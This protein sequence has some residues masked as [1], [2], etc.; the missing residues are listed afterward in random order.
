MECKFT[1]DTVVCL[2]LAIKVE[3]YWNVN[4]IDIISPQAIRGIKV[5]PYWN[6][7]KILLEYM[8]KIM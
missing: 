5:E 2:A 6:V 3:P 8:R 1:S 4:T 7:N